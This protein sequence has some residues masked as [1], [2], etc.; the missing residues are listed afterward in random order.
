MKC[1]T[2][3]LTAP[4]KVKLFLWKTGWVVCGI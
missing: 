4:K 3:Y 2:F 1:Q